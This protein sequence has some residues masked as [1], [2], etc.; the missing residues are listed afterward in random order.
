MPKQQQ[1]CKLPGAETTA[2]MQTTRSA[3]TSGIIRKVRGDVVKK[4]NTDD[5][6]ETD[7]MAETD[8]M[9]ETD[10]MTETDALLE[11]KTDQWEFTS[12]LKWS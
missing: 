12:W 5:T 9:A 1:P 10:A 2:A 11:K 6:S 7:A 4:M 3:L 8:P